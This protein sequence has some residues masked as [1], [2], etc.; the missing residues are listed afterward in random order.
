MNKPEKVKQPIQDKPGLLGRVLGNFMTLRWRLTLLNAAL[1]TVLG[2]LLAGFIYLRLE[3]FLDSGLQS[4]MQDYAAT[5]TYYPEERR[6][7]GRGNN[8][9]DSNLAELAEMLASKPTAEIHPVVLDSSG[10]PVTADH[11]TTPPALLTPLPTADQLKQAAASGG[12]FYT[13]TST[14]NPS[15]PFQ[16]F[17][18]VVK[19]RNGQALMQNNS[20]LGYVFL[21]ASQKPAQD[22]LGEIE[23]LLVIGLSGLILLTVL[24]GYPLTR[25]GL[26]PLQKITNLAR[27]M[28]VSRLDQRV[29]LPNS[30]LPARV[31]SQDEIWQLVLEFNAMLDKIEIAFNAQKQNEARMRQFVADASHELRSPLTILGGYLDVLQMGAL[32]DPAQ[33]DQ[34]VTSLK[35]E[36]D[37]LSHLVIDLLLLTRLDSSEKV[38]VQNVPVDLGDLI[39]RT[40]ANMRV[41]ASS[42][43]IS[44]E[45]VNNTEGLWVSGNADQLYRVLVNLL[46]NAIRYSH[47]GGKVQV[48]LGLENNGGTDWAR[49]EVKDWGV[50]IPADQQTLI[51]NR[52]Y[53]A[54]KS[55]NRETGNAGLGLAISKGIIENHQGN[56]SVESQ[57]DEGTCFIVRLP[58][59]G[60]ELES[61]PA[62][63]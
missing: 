51:F 57:P 62:L 30:G 7:G 39:E 11:A 52:F 46:D 43:G 41:L 50:G 29:P 27:Q 45:T 1:L 24:T 38:G 10:Q 12:L 6:Q 42:F 37:R 31:A 58:L 3:D 17:L 15:E 23:F 47:P 63:V 40:A 25:L 48:R 8:N 32:A 53:R 2:I 28:R 34:I 16:I 20:I 21:A 9:N 33:A 56:I 19:D 14:Q 49:I 60:I 13:A 18:S 36:V 55:R 26:K 4:R 35:Q 61:D 54:D 44:L 5:Q 59:L 22:V